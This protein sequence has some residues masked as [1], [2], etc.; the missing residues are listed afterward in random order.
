LHYGREEGRL[1]P[2]TVI[3]KSRDR[4]SVEG[5]EEGM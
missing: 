2:R 4:K 5:R 3:K 1:K